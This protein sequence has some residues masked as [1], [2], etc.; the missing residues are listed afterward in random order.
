MGKRSLYRGLAKH[1]NHLHT[2]EH[3]EVL[4][5]NY[6]HGLRMNRA[7]PSSITPK[8]TALYD[9]RLDTATKKLLVYWF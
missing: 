7:M 3:G 6:R 1:F 8:S 4:L 9:Y 5:N 2:T